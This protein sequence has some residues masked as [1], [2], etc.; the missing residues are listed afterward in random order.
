MK[1]GE[2]DCMSGKKRGWGVI[3]FFAIRQFRQSGVVHE[4]EEAAIQ[5]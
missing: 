3:P 2:I 5:F 1:Y 4:F